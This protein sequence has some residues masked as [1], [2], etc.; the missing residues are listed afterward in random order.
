MLRRSVSCTARW[1]RSARIWTNAWQKLAIPR[2]ISEI[3]ERDA[4]APGSGGMV[5]NPYSQVLVAYAVMSST[6]CLVEPLTL[7]P[8]DDVPPTITEER[9]DVAGDED[10]NGSADCQDPA[11]AD[12]APCRPRC[13][14]GQLDPSEDLDPPVSPSEWVPVNAQT[15]RFDFSR[16]QQLSCAGTCGTWG[17]GSGCQQADADAFC[18]LKTGNPNSHA[19]RFYLGIA[20]AEPG[21][22]CPSVDASMFGCTPLRQ[23][24]NR[25]VPLLVAVHEANLLSTHG[26]GKVITSVMCAP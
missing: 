18:K 26:P 12:A 4:A 25:G 13:G 9:C 24:D 19:I 5:R 16:I 22:C 2:Q 10:G 21:I 23:F 17:G 7:T 6:A 8:L 3:K 20:T 11:C 15:C 1:A 14:D